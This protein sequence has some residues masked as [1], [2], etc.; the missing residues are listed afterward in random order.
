MCC[1]GHPQPV[2]VIRLLI[3]DD[4]P[5]VRRG[6]EELFAAEPDI[7]VTAT[8]ADAAAAIDQVTKNRPDVVLM[9]ISMPGMG[10]IEA[11]RHVLQKSPDSRVVMPTSFADHEK[12]MESLDNGA[13]GYLLKDADGDELVR[14]VRA[15]AAGESPLSPKAARV[16]IS[17][18]RERR[19]S[20]GSP[21]ASWKC[22]V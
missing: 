14:G 13:V 6:L 16:V 2:S 20:K 5:M 21:P 17:D 15:A 9:D 4:H 3:V 22:C 7:E 19:P 10:G 12:V 8:V 18:R 1:D 11:V